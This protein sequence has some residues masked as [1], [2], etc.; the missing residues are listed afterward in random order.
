MPLWIPSHLL[1]YVAWVFLLLG[2]I[3]LYLRQAERGGLFGLIATVLIFA[4]GTAFAGA[5]LVGASVFQV[6]YPDA[7]DAGAPLVSSPGFRLGFLVIESWILWFVLFAAATLRAGVLPRAGGWLVLVAALVG[8]ATVILLPSSS[9]ALYYI[10]DIA[11]A[12]FA[13]GLGIW[14]RSLWS[15]AAERNVPS[16]SALQVPL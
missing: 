4:S 14:G 10:G 13:I 9:L 15:S 6:Q 2:L 11:V 8:V 7:L 1:G 16:R 12:V 3:G 5:G